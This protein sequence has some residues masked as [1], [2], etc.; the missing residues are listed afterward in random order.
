MTEGAKISLMAAS[1]AG[2]DAKVR[3]LLEPGEPPPHKALV[4]AVES[5]RISTVRILLDHGAEVREEKDIALRLAVAM[6]QDQIAE[7][8]LDQYPPQELKEMAEIA[9]AQQSE[10]SVIIGL[11]NPYPLEEIKR[12]MRKRMVQTLRKTKGTELEI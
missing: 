12:A 9:K 3:L 8:I 10:G 6:G 4:W 11:L 7:M 1:M 2:D 5:N